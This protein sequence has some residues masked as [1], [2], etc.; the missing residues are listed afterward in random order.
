MKAIVKI[1]VPVSFAFA[2]LGAQ[3]AGTIETDYPMNLPSTASHAAAY[4]S[5]GP[6]LVQSNH[7]GVKETAE[8][9]LRTSGQAS[10]Q[11][12][13]GSATGARSSYEKGIADLGY[14]A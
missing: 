10:T 2:A 12:G 4:S 5:G 6:R 14:F 1:L 8:A 3:A 13:K 9:A 7:E 11:A